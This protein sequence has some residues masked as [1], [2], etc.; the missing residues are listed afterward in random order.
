MK[1]FSLFGRDDIIWSGQSI[2]E[3][4]GPFLPRSMNLNMMGEDAGVAIYSQCDR[5]HRTKSNRYSSVNFTFEP[6]NKDVMGFFRTLVGG[7]SRDMN[8]NIAQFLNMIARTII[9]EGRF[10]YELQI[11]LDKDSQKIVEMNFSPVSAPGSRVFILGSRVVQWLPSIIAKEHSCSQI[12]ILN[13][14]NTFIFQAPSRWR[15]ALG[16]ARSTLFFY[17]A[18]KYSLMDQLTESMG[19]G[20]ETVCL[21]DDFSNLKLLA[22]ATA[23]LGW[24][25][26][27][28]FHGY[29]N[30]YLGI[31]RHIRWNR[32]CID[33]R[34]H[35]IVSLKA[36][37]SRI[38]SILD[39]DCQLVVE[40]KSEY[41]LEDVLKK[42]Q[43]GKTSTVELV[44]LLY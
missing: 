12:R 40:E 10:I 6:D 26:R 15:Q 8:Y 3:P 24:L 29:Q 34:N 1:K 37:V 30:D 19:S 2:F 13:P 11:G 27:G 35:M 39:S 22:K 44:R 28:L 18:M 16:K 5:D 21:Y 42:L 31:E 33:L 17:D 32:F 38:A 25:G 7:Q 36:A 14:N 23:P 9:V 43:E 20:K 41:S 4:S